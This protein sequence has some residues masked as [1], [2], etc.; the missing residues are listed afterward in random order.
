VLVP[1]RSVGVFLSGRGTLDLLVDLYIRLGWSI[2]SFSVS[3]GL[4][5]S[6]ESTVKRK[7]G[8]VQDCDERFVILVHEAGS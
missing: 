3:L 6:Y 7:Q 5:W 8:F 2:T 1:T 4:P